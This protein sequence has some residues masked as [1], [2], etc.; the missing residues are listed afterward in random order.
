MAEN[1]RTNIKQRQA[2]GIV[3]AK[4]RGVKFGHPSNPLPNNFEEVCMRW[5]KKE[6]AVSEAAQICGMSTS[7]FFRYAKRMEEK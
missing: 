7:T 6:I 2:E 4:S 5:V 1:E 3:A